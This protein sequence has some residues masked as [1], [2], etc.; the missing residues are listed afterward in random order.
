MLTGKLIVE[1]AELQGMRKGDLDHVKAMLSRNTDRGRP[2]WNRIQ[3]EQP[4]ECIFIGTSNDRG[5]LK[6][7]TGNRRFWP[8]AVKQFNLEA[9]GRDRDQLWGEA[10]ATQAM[11]YSIRLDRSLWGAAAKEQAARLDIATDPYVDTFQ[12]YLGD[13]TGKIASEDAW[14]ILGLAPGHRTPTLNARFCAALRH[15]GWK[16]KTVWIDGKATRGFAKAG[17]RKRIIVSRH[18]DRSVYV[19]REDEPDESET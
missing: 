12:T 15:I 13:M 2:V 3:V 18:S 7:Q 10:A 4:R 8:V 1:C 19:H 11:G 6:D 9:L 17:G 5:Y 14:T 16:A